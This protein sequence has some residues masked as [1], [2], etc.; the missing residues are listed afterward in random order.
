MYGHEQDK[1]IKPI[2]SAVIKRLP[3]YYRHLGQL[4]ERGVT[5]TSSKE[6]ATL[7]NITSSQIRQ[8]LN[9]FGTFGQ[10]G[11]GY[12]VAKLHDAIKTL[13]GV[14]SEHTM[15]IIG[16]GNMGQALG[17]YANFKKRGFKLVGIFDT[18]PTKIGQTVRDLQVQDIAEMT[19]FLANTA[20]DIAVLTVPGPHA[21]MIAAVLSQYPIRGIWNF[22]NIELELAPDSPVMVEDIQL[23]D[24]LMNLSYKLREHEQR[25]RLA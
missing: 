6:L 11:Y 16:F 9:N 1:H 4:L 10:Q 5:K 12:D 24:S 14:D 2:S 7:M 15:I 8:D 3:R 25:E 17:G 22:S 20:V 19:T 18:D 23:T 13:L 21:S